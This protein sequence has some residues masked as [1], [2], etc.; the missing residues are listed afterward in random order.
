[1]MKMIPKSVKTRVVWEEV[2]DEFG[3]TDLIFVAFG[4]KGKTFSKIKQ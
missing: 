3:N 2:K 4:T 1:M